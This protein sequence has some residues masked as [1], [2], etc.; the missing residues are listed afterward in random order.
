[1]IEYH[2]YQLG[3]QVGVL[4]KINIDMS[5]GY[6]DVHPWPEFGDD[7]LEKQLDL[8]KMGVLTPLTQNALEF[9]HIDAKA[10]REGRSLFEG[11]SV[12]D[13]H[14]LIQALDQRSQN[15]VEQAVCEGFNTFKVKLGRNLSE[16]LSLLQPLLDTPSAKWRLDFNGSLTPDKL[17]LMETFDL[18]IDA[19]EF[20]EDPSPQTLTSFP[21]PTAYDWIKMTPYDYRVVK[22]AVDPWKLIEDDKPIIFTTYLGHPVGQAADAFAAAKSGCQQICGLLSHRVYNKNCFSEE[23]SWKGPKWQCPQG[24]GL[25]FDQ[26]LRHLEWVKLL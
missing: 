23:L 6:C 7:P 4:L 9:A 14:F 21:F 22:P 1:M 24:T 2:R 5:E 10:R 11:L 17:K 13:S 15:V 3:S 25:G 20:C 8:L 26:Q 18:R 16:E 12:P 19:I